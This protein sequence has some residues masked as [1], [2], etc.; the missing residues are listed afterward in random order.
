M[1]YELS[2]L[3]DYTDPDTRREVKDAELRQHVLDI[4]DDEPWTL[5]RTQLLEKLGGRR[6]TARRVVDDMLKRIGGTNGTGGEPGQLVLHK[7][8]E[9]DKLGRNSTKKKVGKSVHH[10]PN[11]PPPP[12]PSL[13]T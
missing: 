8:S 2:E 4:L 10:F 5:G 13:S 12:K 9:P 11:Y 7:V 3:A 6:D 1:S